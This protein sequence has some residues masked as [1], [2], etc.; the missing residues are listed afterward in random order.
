M[1]EVPEHILDAIEV[2]MKNNVLAL[3]A[4]RNLRGFTE[5]DEYIVQSRKALITFQ[6]WRHDGS[7]IK[8]V[9]AGEE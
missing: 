1:K 3:E 6:A 8:L 5:L 7:I 4:V 2:S 9:D